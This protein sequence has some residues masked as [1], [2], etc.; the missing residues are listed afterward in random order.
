MKE[1]L[2]VNKK[3]DLEKRLIDFAVL[4]IDLETWKFDVRYSVFDI[5]R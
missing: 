1:E 5:C 2:D 3:Y 4:I